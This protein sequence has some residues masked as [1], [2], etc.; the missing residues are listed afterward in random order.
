MAMALLGAV[1][2]LVLLGRRHDR[3]IAALERGCDRAAGSAVRT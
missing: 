3:Q 2:A 1:S